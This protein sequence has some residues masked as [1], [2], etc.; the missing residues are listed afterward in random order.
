[1]KPKDRRYARAKLRRRRCGC[2]T[3]IRVHSEDCKRLQASWVYKM[4]WGKHKGK[5]IRT[6]GTGYLKVIA[7][8]G[9]GKTGEVWEEI[10]RVLDERDAY[11]GV[12]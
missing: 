10:E 7:R 5:D 1:M 8:F 4:P 11:V 9:I 2:C 3:G 12:S 6:L